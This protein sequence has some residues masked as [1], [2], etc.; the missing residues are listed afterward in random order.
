[1][2]VPKQVAVEAVDDPARPL[3]RFDDQD[4]DLANVVA[5]D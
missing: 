4:D 2:R 5:S 1:M 3:I